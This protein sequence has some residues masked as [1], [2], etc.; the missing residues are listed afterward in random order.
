M[1]VAA[2]LEA[3]AHA[4]ARPSQVL[5]HAWKLTRS[6]GRGRLDPA[7]AIDGGSTHCCDATQ[8]FPRPAIPRGREGFEL[9]LARGSD[10][11]GLSTLGRMAYRCR[12]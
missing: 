9:P 8:S 5:A 3:A 11:G 2:H 6:Y 1:V 12:R 4:A 7:A 10:G